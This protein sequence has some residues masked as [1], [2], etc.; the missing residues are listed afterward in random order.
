MFSTFH[1]E[2][3]HIFL[4]KTLSSWSFWLL[5]MSELTSSEAMQMRFVLF[6]ATKMT[7]MTLVPASLTA[8]KTMKMKFFSKKYITIRREMY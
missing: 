1:D 8:K 4:E 6:R 7:R 5:K 3:Q 2:L